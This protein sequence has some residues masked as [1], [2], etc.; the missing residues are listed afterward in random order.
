MKHVIEAVMNRIKQEV[1]EIGF[2]NVDLGQLSVEVPP[3]DFPCALVDV[4]DVNYS[5][6]GTLTQTA[7]ATV[8]L[9]LGFKV[10]APSD[11]NADDE[12]RAE[13][14]QHFDLV[15]KVAEALHG[16]GTPQFAAL[17]RTA[18]TRIPDTFPR[19]FILSFTT[20]WTESR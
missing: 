9:R 15:E 18:L 16:Y 6:G 20:M 19:H 8:N 2:I 12:Q 17:K 14:M 11:V 7:K 1:P 3:V 10:Y 5:S 13:A 4:L